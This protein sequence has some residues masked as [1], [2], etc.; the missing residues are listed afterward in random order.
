MTLLRR[1]SQRIPA[2]VFDHLS[3]RGDEEALRF[4]VAAA[5]YTRR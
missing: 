3:A 4:S 2:A 5:A 1:A